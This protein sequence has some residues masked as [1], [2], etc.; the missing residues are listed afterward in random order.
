M[1]LDTLPL[2]R[3]FK[4]SQ[5]NR[6]QCKF[7]HLME[8]YVEVT[9]GKVTVCRDSVKGK[10]RRHLCKYYHIPVILSALAAPNLTT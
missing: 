9:E 10:C 2:C 5:C 7:V 1:L 6:P 4:S 8:D 3:D